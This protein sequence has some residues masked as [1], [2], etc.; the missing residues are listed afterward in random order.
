MTHGA[1]ILVVDDEPQILRSLRTTLASHGY[2]VQTAAT[3][4]EALAAVDGRLPDL[5]VLDLVLPGLSG[6]EVCR[7]LRARS[8]LPILVLSARGDERDKVAAL[9]LGADDYLTKPFGVN[10][11]LA[12]IRAALRRAVGA[13][14]PSAVVE[15]G[16]LRV[17]FDRR[18]VT[19]DGAEVRLTPTE[20]EL[21][22][23]LVANAGRVLTHGYLL[24]TVWGPEYEGESQLLRVFI[25]QLR[26]KV[27]RDPS[28]PQHIL[29][30]PGVGY[31]F[32]ID[33]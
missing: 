22:K 9:D 28:R 23:V 16:A 21:L 11:L 2:D 19:L 18:Q 13:R 32:R 27:E 29:T 4:E 5:V 17:D 8:S 7:R 1:R 12:R 14:G 15:A 10:E 31:R 25:G 3:G 6:L 30:D 26:R 20:F 24:R 33:D